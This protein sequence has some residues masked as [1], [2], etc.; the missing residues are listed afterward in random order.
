M[1]QKKHR[2][3]AHRRWRLF[4]A[5]K[6]RTSICCVPLSFPGSK[7]FSCSPVVRLQYSQGILTSLTTCC[8]GNTSHL[9]PVS[10]VRPIQPTSHRGNNNGRQPNA[11]RR[12]DSICLIR[13]ARNEI[14]KARELPAYAKQAG[15]V[16]KNEFGPTC[17]DNS[18]CEPPEPMNPQLS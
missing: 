10:P 13:L 18:I 2:P 11:T 9:T 5:R 14:K 6:S 12:G 3:R 8:Q 17:W 16:E 4:S 15:E 7:G 1:M